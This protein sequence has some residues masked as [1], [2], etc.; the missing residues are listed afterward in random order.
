MCRFLPT[1]TPKSFFSGLPIIPLITQ[2]VLVFGIALT[3]V[4]DLALGRIELH[5]VPTG[6]SLKP[7]DDIPSLQQVNCTT[8]LS[9]ISAE[10]VLDTTVHVTDKRC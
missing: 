5:E 7:L 4:Q 6:Y 3:Q 9:V 10:D 8:Q 2:S 1:N